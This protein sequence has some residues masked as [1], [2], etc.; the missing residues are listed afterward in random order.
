M[1]NIFFT[2]DTHFN[3]GN[4]I[5]YC[6]RPFSDS[7]EMDEVLI[8]NWNRV[9]KTTDTVYHL[10]D[11]GFLRTPEAVFSYRKKLNGA[12]V[13]I[14]GSH[15]RRSVMQSSLGFLRIFDL[16]TL[17][18]SAN[19]IVLCHWAMR[20]WHKSYHGSWHLYGHSHGRLADFPDSLSMDV[21]VDVCNYTPMS[22]DEVS[23]KLSAKVPAWRAK[24]DAGKEV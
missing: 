15:D 16:Y 17:R 18:T 20:T 23:A 21:G 3:H 12:I 9:V 4:I 1:S 10:G 5:K 13:L 22:L 24:K 2:A 6:N 7:K 19:D 14:V 8:E 11:F